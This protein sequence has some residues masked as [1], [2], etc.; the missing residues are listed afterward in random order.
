M[1]FYR[2]Q[3]VGDTEKAPDRTQTG[4]LAPPEPGIAQSE[5][6]AIV[7][8]QEDPAAIRA[9]TEVKVSL[10]GPREPLFD[11]SG[12]MAPRWYRF[13]SE[14][15]RRTGGTNDNVNFFGQFRQLESTAGSV[16]LTGAAPSAEIVHSKTPTVGS[17]GLSSDAPTLA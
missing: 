17:L 1:P 4:F 9:G 12:M 15:Y 5:S 8:S 11:A 10:P 14:L 3:I 6:G 7:G 13:F 16:S 2:R